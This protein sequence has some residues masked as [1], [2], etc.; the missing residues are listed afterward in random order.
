MVHMARLVLALVLAVADAKAN[1]MDNA[2]NA[3]DASATVLNQGLKVR[4]MSAMSRPVTILHVSDTHSLHRSTG[5]LPDAASCS[6]F[7]CALC[8]WLGCN[9]F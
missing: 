1:A 4:S 7:S 6:Q 2:T 8:C 3:T 9:F 5:N